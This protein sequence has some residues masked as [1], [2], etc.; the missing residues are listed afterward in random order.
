[1]GDSIVNRETERELDQRTD[2]RD[3]LKY[4]SAST[5]EK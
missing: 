3:D 5:V 4:S 2:R 1:M